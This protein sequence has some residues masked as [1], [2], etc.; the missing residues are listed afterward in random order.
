MARL[1]IQA[2]PSDDLH[3]YRLKIGRRRVRMNSQNQGCIDVDGECGDE[4]RLRLS[5]GLVGDVG[6]TLGLAMTCDGDRDIPLPDLE[7]F[8]PGPVMGGAVD[9]R[10]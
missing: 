8:P 1:C 2:T 5:Y 6:A 9:F 4:R 3:E 10:L 7:I